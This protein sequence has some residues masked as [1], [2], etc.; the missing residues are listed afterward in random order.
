MEGFS[1]WG[2]IFRAAGTSCSRPLLGTFQV[3]GNS[4]GNARFVINTNVSLRMA[5]VAWEVRGTACRIVRPEKQQVDDGFYSTSGGH[6]TKHSQMGG[7][8][9]WSSIESRRSRGLGHSSSPKP[10]LPSPRTDR[11]SPQAQAD[12]P[13]LPEDHIC[14][15]RYA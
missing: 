12:T 7:E 11:A 5:T 2:E 10:Q 1:I 8:L 13:R 9:R 6:R 3:S 4:G 14:G 15:G